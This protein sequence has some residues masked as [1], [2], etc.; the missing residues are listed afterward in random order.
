VLEQNNLGPGS[1][2]Q[3][4]LVRELLASSYAYLLEA[5]ALIAALHKSNEEHRKDPPQ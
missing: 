3:R 4:A 5:E 1:E 2:R